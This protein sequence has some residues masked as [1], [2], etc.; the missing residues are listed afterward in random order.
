L[1]RK[2]PWIGKASAAEL[3]EA[4]RLVRPRRPRGGPIG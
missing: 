4:P 1:P 2:A 3:D